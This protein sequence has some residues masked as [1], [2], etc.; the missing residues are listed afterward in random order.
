[1]LKLT[2]YDWKF[3]NK[4]IGGLFQA[5]SE[6]PTHLKEVVR[7]IGEEIP[8]PSK[9]LLDTINISNSRSYFLPYGLDCVEEF[10]CR[11]KQYTDLNREYELV[12][13]TCELDEESESICYQDYF[14][15]IVN[16][17]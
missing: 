16:C 1:M 4:V 11:I 3:Q 8:A 13:T 12:Q 7:L 10:I 9:Y 5:S 14:Q 6:L 17:H 15:V 2:R